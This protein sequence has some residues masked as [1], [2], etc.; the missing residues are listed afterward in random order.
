MKVLNGLFSIICYNFS[1]IFFAK[2]QLPKYNKVSFKPLFLGDF[3]KN[4][5]KNT[6]KIIGLF[7]LLLKSI[8]YLTLFLTL[9]L[10]KNK[11]LAPVKIFKHL[12][13]G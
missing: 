5:E 9:F 7:S 12:Y 8:F 3:R 2:K 4:R 13:K 1:I 10:M 6:S 11:F